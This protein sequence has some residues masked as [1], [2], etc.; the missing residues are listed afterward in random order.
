MMKHISNLRKEHSA[1]W[2]TRYQMIITVYYRNHASWD[3]FNPI[4]NMIPN[5]LE[6]FS[7]SSIASESLI[8]MMY[9]TSPPR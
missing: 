3:N 9:F 6:E 1:S 5:D 8:S 4:K 2:K 7:N